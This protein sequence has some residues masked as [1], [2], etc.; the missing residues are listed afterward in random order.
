MEFRLLLGSMDTELKRADPH[1][2]PFNLLQ[3]HHELFH[4][5][6]LE[7]TNIALV[8]EHRPLAKNEA[9]HREIIQFGHCHH[10]LAVWLVLQHRRQLCCDGGVDPPLILGPGTELVLGHCDLAH[11]LLRECL[12]LL[13]HSCQDSNA[14]H[15]VGPVDLWD[16]DV[17]EDHGHHQVP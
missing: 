9:L 2:Y 11:Q 16:Q 7:E 5:S 3:G 14:S 10:D 12:R 17:L 4:R 1:S 15:M 13:I 6:D 8:F